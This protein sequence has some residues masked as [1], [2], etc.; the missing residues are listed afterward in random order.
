MVEVLFL[1]SLV[2]VAF[3][4]LYFYLKRDSDFRMMNFIIFTM[5]LLM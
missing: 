1:I 2:I 4:V 3:G 5:I